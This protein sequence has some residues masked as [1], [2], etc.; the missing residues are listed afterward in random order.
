M[1]L[2]VLNEAV[3][4][5]GRLD[6][7]I[8]KYEG[9]KAKASG[10][11]EFTYKIIIDKLANIKTVEELH[12]FLK[13]MSNN[14]KDESKKLIASKP[15]PSNLFATKTYQT[16]VASYKTSSSLFNEILAFYKK[17]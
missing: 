12:A 17:L 3:D 8:A 9:L 6:P 14:L 16:R 11:E 2:T 15:D 13:L 7:L 5:A 4:I 1:K 10:N